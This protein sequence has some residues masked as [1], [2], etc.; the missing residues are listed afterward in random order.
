M[1]Y[2]IGCLKRVYLGGVFSLP[3]FFFLFIC[4]SI[5]RPPFWGYF[6]VK[7]SDFG[8][9]FEHPKSPFWALEKYSIFGY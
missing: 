8:F 9:S 3:S 2:R 1:K 4:A 7:K 6:G 5:T